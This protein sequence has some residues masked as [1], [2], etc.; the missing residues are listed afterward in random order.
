MIFPHLFIIICILFLCY[1]IILRDQ[2]E[3]ILRQ[4][5]NCI[6][7]KFFYF[8]LTTIADSV[9]ASSLHRKSTDL[10]PSVKQV[11]LYLERYL[12][13]PPTASLIY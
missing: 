5:F 12:S 10:L 13:A 11:Y 9:H 3:N 7:S 8:S 1:S 2:S 6:A 4:I